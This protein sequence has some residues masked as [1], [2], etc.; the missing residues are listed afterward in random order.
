MTVGQ[1]QQPTPAG[2][3]TSA[4]LLLTVGLFILAWAAVVAL[5]SLVPW[6]LPL[7]QPVWQVRM[8]RLLSA[9]LVGAALSVAGVV[10]QSLLRN[11]LASPEVLGI[12][13]GAT[14]AALLS[15][16]LGSWGVPV[17]ADMEGKTAAAAIG[18]MA[19]I[20]A[21]YFL[22]Q[23]RGRLDPYTLLL[24]GIIV[25]AFNG[26]VIM[27]LYR[28]APPSVFQEMAFWSM[29]QVSERTKPIELAIA[30]GVIVLSWV[31]VITRAKA[32]NV[33]S[34]GDDVAASSGVNVQALRLMT[35]G[36]VAVMTA[37]AV[38]LAGPVS[39]IGLIVPH[40]TRRLLGADHRLLVL[41]AGFVGASFLAA[42]DTLCR[43]S[44]FSQ[45]GELPVGIITTAAGGPFF[46]YLL[47]KRFR[48]RL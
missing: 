12:S 19:T 16:I 23:R 24:T 45:A 20:A 15:V 6:W 5:C 21:V 29:G 4:R 42:A 1:V 38:S 13:S 25:T 27:F 47:R 44:V 3:F 22:A 41:T 35:F 48:E 31:A 18:G 40:V 32:F 26:A 8:Y 17:A 10:L 43:V 30:A 2:S 14:V 36:A 33:Q 46:L 34:L 11:P 7:S 39:F 9:S 28:I 37:A